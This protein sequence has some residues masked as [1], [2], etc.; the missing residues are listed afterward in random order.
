M[1]HP[2]HKSELEALC[3]REGERHQ[4]ALER[5][6]NHSTVLK[7]RKDKTDHIIINTVTFQ[8]LA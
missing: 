4:S 7:V 8:D 6:S 3:S 1:G 2:S 5:I